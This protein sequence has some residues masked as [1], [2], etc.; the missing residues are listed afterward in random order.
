MVNAGNLVRANDPTPLVVI[1]QVTPISVAFGVPEAQL[2]DLRRYMSQGPVYVEVQPAGGQGPAARGRVAFVDNAVDQTTG[3]I[4]VKATFSNEN[5]LLWPGQF[6]NLA[7]TLTTDRDAIVVPTVAVQ[8]GPEG[9]HVFV[10][11]PDNTVDLRPVSVERLAGGET[12]IKEGLSAGE[13]VVTD[14]QIRLVPGSRISLR[15]DAAPR[16]GQ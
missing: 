13:T 2:A 15:A 11:K 10:V 12:V 3:T 1:N 8:A 14:G 6:V 4:K 5:R 9:D 16:S 7:V